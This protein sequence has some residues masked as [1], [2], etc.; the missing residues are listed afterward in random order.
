[1]NDARPDGLTRILGRYAV[2]DEIAG[3]GM[4]TVHL[5]RLIGTGGFSRT[6]A[7]KRLHG[8]FAKDPEFVKMFLDEARLAARVRH[9]NVVSILDVESME[10]ELFL[11]MDLVQGE[12]LARL[13]RASGHRKQ[14]VPLPIVSAIMVGMLDGLHAAH[15]AKSERGEPLGIVHRDI[16]PQNILVSQD[17]VA[18]L[19]DFGVARAA[20][21]LQETRSGQIKG[22]IAYMAPEQFRDSD[23]VDR[24]T[25]IYAASAVLWECLT[26]KRL[27]E[28]ESQYELYAR[29]VASD[30]QRPSEFVPGLPA[31][32][33]EITM[34]GLASDPA[35]RFRTAAQ[36]A[37]KIEH[38]IPP[39]SPREVA[40]WVDNIAKEKLAQLAERVAEVEAV[41]VT[42]PTLQALLMSPQTEATTVEARPPIFSNP[43]PTSASVSLSLSRSAVINESSLSKEPATDK[44]NRLVIALAAA[45]VVLLLLVVSGGA[46]FLGG[47]SASNSPAPNF[48][49]VPAATTEPSVAKSAATRNDSSGD[50]PTVSATA[51]ASTS[52]SAATATPTV[53]S[54]VPKK[55]GGSDGSK[56]GGNCSPPYTLSADGIRVPKPECM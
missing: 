14:R 36:L 47:R 1:M 37:E 10:G 11:V 53:T 49:A 29:I 18:R 26:N 42:M 44:S 21:R 43:S 56:A 40:R 13:L 35:D 55:S 33:D 38:V 45:V 31:Q 32:L 30:F 16:S 25:D 2:F 48:S 15:E 22:K 52:A 3:G 41:S 51:S 20:G 50:S 24:R 9:P 54:K 12:S 28:G 27:L 7:I 8:H 46:F 39:A 5:G 23:E 4:A 19:I 34:R 17:G 6:V